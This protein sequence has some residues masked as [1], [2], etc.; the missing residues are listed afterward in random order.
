MEGTSQRDPVIAELLSRLQENEH[1]AGQVGVLHVR[2]GQMIEVTVREISAAIKANPDHPKAKDMALGIRGLPAN[3][4]LTVEQVDLE[5][6]LKNK[7]VVYIKEME[8]LPQLPDEEQADVEQ[9]QRKVLE[10][11]PN[12]VGRVTSTEPFQ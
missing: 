9:V 1:T 6:I 4:K 10:D 11:D 7:Q 5:A 3:Q 8:S 2:E 12:V